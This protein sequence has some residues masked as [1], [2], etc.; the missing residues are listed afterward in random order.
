MYVQ[1]KDDPSK[2]MVIEARNYDTE[3]VVIIP[4]G[5]NDITGEYGDVR[6]YNLQGIEVAEPTAGNIYI[7]VDG[8]GSHKAIYTHP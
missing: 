6:Y 4:T 3:N 5:V 7:R 8:T 2:Y 1:P